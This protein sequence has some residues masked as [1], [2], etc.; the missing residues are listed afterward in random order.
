VVVY[1]NPLEKFGEVKVFIDN[2]IHDDK[3]VYI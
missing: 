3:R 2:A 1:V